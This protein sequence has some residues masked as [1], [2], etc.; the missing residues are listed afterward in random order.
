MT[1][2]QISGGLLG[3]LVAEGQGKVAVLR[4]LENGR[5]EITLQGTGKMLGVDF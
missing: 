3:E 1:Q 4:A 5:I 2:Q